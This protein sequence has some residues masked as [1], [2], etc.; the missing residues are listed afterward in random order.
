MHAD[1]NR[2]KCGSPHKIN[3]R[4]RQ[5]RL[6]SR[7]MSFGNHESSFLREARFRS[8]ANLFAPRTGQASP[9]RTGYWSLTRFCPKVQFCSLSPFVT[10]HLKYERRNPRR[11][12]SRRETHPPDSRHFAFPFLCVRAPLNSF[13]TEEKS[14]F[15][16]VRRA[17]G[18]PRKSQKTKERG[19]R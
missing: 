10:L 19:A 3:Y 1:P 9:F 12:N 2:Q 6:P 18:I 14:K 5:Q 13:P 17:N 8:R 11:R 16:S 7:A 15:E 4:E